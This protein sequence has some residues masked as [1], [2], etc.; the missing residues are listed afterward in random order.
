M[1]EQMD[2]VRNAF[3]LHKSVGRKSYRRDSLASRE[4]I[5]RPGSKRYQRWFNGNFLSEQACDLESNAD[6]RLVEDT[7]LFRHLFEAENGE[8]WA[9]FCDVTEDQQE[10]LFM[11]IG[12]YPKEKTNVGT[13]LPPRLCSPAISFKK[14]DK[15]IRGIFDRNFNEELLLQL[16]QEMITYVQKT[17]STKRVY[18]FKETFH[19]LMCRGVAQFYSLKAS[20][21]D[22]SGGQRELVISKPPRI[23][24][25]SKTLCQYLKV[26]A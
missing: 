7:S 5:G 22:S 1:K 11:S 14:I 26:Q 12:Y 15:T 20:S 17:D 10:E 16:D 18:I 2:S 19:R 8:L 9:P 21:Q 6:Y 25:P 3:P 13:A 24:L 23:I 4:Q